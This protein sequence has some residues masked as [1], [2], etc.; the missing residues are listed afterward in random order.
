MTTRSRVPAASSQGKRAR[1]KPRTRPRKRAQSLEQAAQQLAR[2]NTLLDAWVAKLLVASRK[3]DV[4]RKKSVYYQAQVQTR[5]A[6]LQAAMSRV[7]EE[8]RL[9]REQQLRDLEQRTGRPSRAID[10]SGR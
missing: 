6:E 3:V 7:L 1:G 2:Y 10:L 9:L 4:Y 5:T 8:D